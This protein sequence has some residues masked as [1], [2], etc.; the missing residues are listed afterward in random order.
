MLYYDIHTHHFRPGPDTVAIY[1]RI[2]PAS[3]V[4]LPD[5]AEPARTAGAFSCYY[6]VGIHPWYIDTEETERQ[7]SLFRDCARLPGVIA[8]GEGG[9]DKLAAAPLGLQEEVFRYQAAVAEEIRK[10]M[11][12]HCVK[13]WGEMLALRKKLSPRMPWVIHG[14]RGNPVLASQLLEHGFYLSVSDRFHPGIFSEAL[15]PRLFLETDDRETDIRAVYRKA[16]SYF[17]IDEETLGLQIG[18][19]VRRVFSI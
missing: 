6:S 11:I 10:P 17:P 13:A 1:N 4:S 3:G 16:A 19:N 8:V 14:F 9:L 15:L 5:A 2:V 18:E 7:F 12:I